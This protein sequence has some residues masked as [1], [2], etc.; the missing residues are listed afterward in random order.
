MA[1]DD[2]KAGLLSAGSPSDNRSGDGNQLISGFEPVGVDA[3]APV[4][5][6]KGGAGQ[7]AAGEV[8]YSVSGG[9]ANRLAKLNV[10]LAF[11][12]YQ[13]GLLYFIGRNA[14]GGVNI[15]QAG[16]PKPMGLCLDDHGGLTLTGDY[17]ILRFENVLEPDQRVNNVFDACYVP[18]TVHVTGRLDAHDVG[19]DGE[20]RPI[21]VNTRYNCLATVSARHS[22]EPI[23]RPP[24]ISALIDEDRCHLNGLA[25]EDGR[26][27]Y[28]TAVSRS[29]TIDGWRDRRSDGGI[30]IDVDSGETVCTGL[31]M[32]H[33]PRLH[34]GKLFVLNSGTGE[35]GVVKPGDGG[36]GSFEPLV[37][38]PGF[39]RGLAFHGGLAFVGLSKPR[40]KRFEGLA[41][42]GKLQAA[43]S[44]PW[45]GIQIIDLATG[46]CVDW[47]RID[48]KIGELY[49]LEIIPGFAC[50]MAV[51]P[52][53]NEA[54]TLITFAPDG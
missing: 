22:F 38:C 15:H 32:P 45:C 6:A 11:T 7:P 9:L 26:P 31:S 52:T 5:A 18:R 49:D 4:P 39:L 19:L 47:L 8:D 23:W 28:A 36:A 17:Q 41:L 10:S 42:D 54:A 24:F 53:T 46:T 27:R 16:M 33:S 50:P 2:D 37:F 14:Q 35:L 48:G 34:D 25:M 12:S 30:V 51:G 29:D 44:E 21:F 43:D 3:G 20:G 1:S 40:Y 13:S